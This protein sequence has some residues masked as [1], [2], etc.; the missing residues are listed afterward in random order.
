[1]VLVNN[2]KRTLNVFNRI[3]A[4]LHNLWAL[5]ADVNRKRSNYE[6]TNI[7]GEDHVYTD[8][9]FEITK[10]DGK[11]VV[12]IRKVAQGNA[13]RSIFYMADEYDLPI[14]DGMRE[15]LVKWNR[16]DSLLVMRCEEIIR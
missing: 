8:C 9:D 1:M 3:E 16:S 10:V 4:D 5:R 12:E 14:S 13:A 15:L 6:F 11:K 2:V 7:A